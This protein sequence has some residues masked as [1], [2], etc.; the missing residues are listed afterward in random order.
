MDVDL[1][2]HL[3]K[4]ESSCSCSFSD[5]RQ[6]LR[7]EYPR[8]DLRLLER[9]SALLKEIPFSSDRQRSMLN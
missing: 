2:L 9:E 5:L 1:R 8:V 4:S 3:D 6:G 7:H